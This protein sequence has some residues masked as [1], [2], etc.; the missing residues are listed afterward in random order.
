[1]SG[2]NTQ[3]NSTPSPFSWP[4]TETAANVLNTIANEGSLGLL[5]VVN[6]PSAAPVAGDFNEFVVQAGSIAGAPVN[7]ALSSGFSVI[8]DSVANATIT[9]A[10]TMDTVLGGNGMT[11]WDH[12]ANESVITQAG[13]NLIGMRANHSENL[14]ALLGGQSDEVAV[15]YGNASLSGGGASNL[16]FGSG[17]NANATLNVSMT[18]GV[19]T[20]VS[21]IGQNIVN[22]NG[23][24]DLVFAGLGSG[25]TTISGSNST[26]VAGSGNNTVTAGAGATVWGETGSLTV[27]ETAPNT[28]V[29]STG[30][31]TVNDSA[32][33][34]TLY[35]LGSGTMTVNGAGVANG[36]TQT[37]TDDWNNPNGGGIVVNM[38]NSNEVFDVFN[39]QATVNIGANNAQQNNETVNFVGTAGGS[40]TQVNSQSLQSANI[41]IYSSGSVDVTVT[42]GKD[43]ISAAHASGNVTMNFDVTSPPLM[44]GGAGATTLIANSTNDAMKTTA[45]FSFQEGSGTTNI[46]LNAQNTEGAP[47]NLGAF[48]VNMSNTY[49]YLDGIGNQTVA[50]DILNSINE[51]VATN[52]Q[53]TAS[54][55]FGIGL[56]G[57]SFTVGSYHVDFTPSTGFGHNESSLPA[58]HV[59]LG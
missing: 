3:N 13:D 17:T 2:T 16:I 10:D 51:Q 32:A 48:D 58:S 8:Y 59:I 44:V 41:N 54:S 53:I 25:A 52:N 33:N 11:L 15:G 31:L 42:G 27:N 47:I 21:G 4:S 18:S 40:V 24:G 29:A 55:P 36:G 38:N 23:A 20:I 45:N 6:S 34:D 49:I 5:N 39:G 37:I 30:G 35:T 26:Y 46:I 43:T 12:S 57:P 1:M 28:V 7:D 56:A 22:V 50:N 19:S 9:S 14:T